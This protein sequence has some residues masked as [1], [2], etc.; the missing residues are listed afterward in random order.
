M[1]RK[2]TIC[3]VVVEK[4]DDE[5]GGYLRR[6]VVCGGWKRLVAVFFAFRLAERPLRIIPKYK[7]KGPMTSHELD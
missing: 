5:D 1:M 3:F 6:W 7:S 4:F 2:G